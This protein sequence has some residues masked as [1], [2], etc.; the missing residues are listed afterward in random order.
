[1]RSLLLLLVL[2]TFNQS[3]SQSADEKRTRDNLARYKVKNQ[4]SW[5]YKYAGDKPEKNGIKT[6]VTTYTVS[7]DVI[8]VTTFN[9]KGQVLHIE[10]YA[11][12]PGGNRTEYTRYTGGNEEKAAYQKISKYNDKKLVIEESGFDGVEN[13]K[14]LY[15]YD[16][17]GIMTDIRYMKNNVL[18]EKRLFSRDGTTTTVSIYNAAGTLTSKLLMKYDFRE[19][20]IEETVYGINQSEL[21]KKTYHYDDKKNLKE[22]SKFKLDKV[23]LKTVYN[24]N[25]AGNLVEI[26][27]E[28]AGNPKFVKKTFA[29]DAKGNLVEIKWRRR[30]NED[31]NSITY[32]WD[33]RGICTTAD[34]WYPGTKYRVLTRYGYEYYDH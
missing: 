8:R 33:D 13:F 17:R 28:S 12:D 27:E 11:Y 23:T 10:K 25:P 7:G 1:M 19:N 30:G 16:A 34:T 21:E 22:E 20:L 24:Y 9:A 32:T 26:I 2:F 6:S 14:N 15:G 4:I 31:Y 29:Y 3:Y 5:D 18:Q